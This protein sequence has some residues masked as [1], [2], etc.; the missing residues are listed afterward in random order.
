MRPN[1]L[2]LSSRVTHCTLESSSSMKLAMSFRA[3]LVVV[4]TFWGHRQRAHTKRPSQLVATHVG[5]THVVGGG[6]GAVRPSDRASGFLQSL[7]GLGRCH[8]VNKMPVC[9]GNR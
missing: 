7:K 6:Q 4:G 1:F 2:T 3:F 5:S 8:F 9:Q